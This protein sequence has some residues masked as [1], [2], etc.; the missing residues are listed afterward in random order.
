MLSFVF[1]SMCTALFLCCTVLHCLCGIY[2]LPYCMFAIGFAFL[3]GCII[4][5]LVSKKANYLVG[6]AGFQC[7]FWG[8]GDFLMLLL[9]GNLPANTETPQLI[10]WDTKANIVWLVILLLLSVCT[11]PFAQ[12]CAVIYKK[13]QDVANPKKRFSNGQ[14]SALGGIIFGTLAV[15]LLDLSSAYLEKQIYGLILC[16]PLLLLMFIFQMGS[17]SFIHYK[18]LCNTQ[19]A[20][21]DKLDLG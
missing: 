17:L 19:K 3:I 10:E 20:Q 12:K 2:A 4:Y 9:T 21:C 15:G 7:A 1:G 8:T 11:V 13:N 5:V 18:K 14:K 6:F 16:I